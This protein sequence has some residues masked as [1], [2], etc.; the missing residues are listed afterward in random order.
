MKRLFSVRYS[1]GAFNAATLLLRLVF[2]GVMMHHGY[3]KLVGFGDM[4]NTF[5]NFLGIGSSMSL[6]LVVFAEFFCALFLIL[7]LFTRFSALV[8][9][10][11][12]AVAFFMAH[13]GIIWGEH[14][15]EMALLYFGAYVA[16]LFT[17]PG[18]I[19]VDSL[20]GK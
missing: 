11:C 9:T 20:I 3:G 7:G 2:G 6:A 19:S 4:R 12:M 13:K 10:I 5:M 8:L 16:L 17:G 18:K 14:G 15:G 1:D